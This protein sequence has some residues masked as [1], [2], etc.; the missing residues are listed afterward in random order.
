MGSRNCVGRNLALVETH[1]YI[2]AFVRHFDAEVARPEQ[3]WKTKSQWFALQ[4]D[5]EIHMTERRL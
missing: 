3:P 4:Q 1:K 5:F 2:A